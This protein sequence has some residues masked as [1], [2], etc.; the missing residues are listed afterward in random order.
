LKNAL[1]PEPPRVDVFHGGTT[2]V[3]TGE[4]VARATHIA[5]ERRMS[6]TDRIRE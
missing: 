3:E 6:A 2:N 1:K 4:A 5:A